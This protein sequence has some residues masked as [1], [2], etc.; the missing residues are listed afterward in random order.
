MRGA[1]KI[2]H[3]GGFFLTSSVI[4]FRIF[5]WTRCLQQKQ[6]NKTK[7]V[8]SPKHHPT[9]EFFSPGSVGQFEGLPNLQRLPHAW[10]KSTLNFCISAAHRCL[11]R[12]LPQKGVRK[13]FMS[14]CCTSLPLVCTATPRVTTFSFNLPNLCWACFVS[15]CAGF[16][17]DF[18]GGSFLDFES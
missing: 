13:L 16:V 7:G 1:G 12:E 18:L 14:Q 8:P 9:P 5:P 3:N 11:F 10:F 6:R 2:C 17:L 4:P 15:V